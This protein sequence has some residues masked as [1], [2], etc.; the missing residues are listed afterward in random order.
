MGKG[1]SISYTEAVEKITAAAQVVETENS[2]LAQCSGRVLAQ[3]V[4]AA[5][6]VP[7]FDRSPYDGYAFKA[8]DVAEASEENPVTLKVVDYI[9]AG[10]VSHCP[11]TEGTAVRLMTGAPIPEGADCVT[12]YE[13]TEWTD[14]EVKIFKPGKVGDNIVYAGEDIKKGQV[15]ANAGTVIDPG[16]EG[17]L[18][19][20]GIA[21]P[22]VYKKL[23][24][25]LISTGSELQG[26]DEELRPG[27]IY[28]SNQYTFTAALEKL[29]FE[30]VRYGIARDTVEIISAA[31]DKALEECDAVI[32]TGGVSV[33][34][35][36]LTPAAMEMS[37]AEIL[38]RGVGLKPG[39][40]C[41]F[42]VKNGK[43]IC[44]LS[45]NPAS[46]LTTFYVVAVPGL[47]K[48]AGIADYNY[49]EITVTLASDFNKK[50]RGTRVL[51]GRLDL[52]DGTVK[53]QISK[54]Q[55]NV[56]LSSTIGADCMA[57]IPAGSGPQPAGTQLKGFLI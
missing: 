25:G 12:M 27:M 28:D 1:K 39:M 8:A 29:G 46:S 57:F 13:A 30:A 52:S 34:D 11:V 22:L 5:D 32:M 23:K 42:G 40:S 53:M 51:R 21:E 17:T 55:G 44:G 24:V 54:D 9:P 35:F 18:A 45:G 6:N 36:D 14:K 4:V 19:S 20:Q 50:S 38:F 49:K 41:A 15:L 31:I 7:Q 37:G 43:L 16:L 2:L 47:K 3:D 26:V 33:G 56:V 48:M 10:E